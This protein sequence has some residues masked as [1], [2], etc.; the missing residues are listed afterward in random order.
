[1]DP[2]APLAAVTTE[3]VGSGEAA[4]VAPTVAAVSMVV[5]SAVEDSTAAVAAITKREFL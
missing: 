1:M 2:E 5:D 4:A 3:E